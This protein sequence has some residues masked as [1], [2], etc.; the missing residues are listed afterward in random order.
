MTATPQPDQTAP[1]PRQLP[2]DTARE[3]FAWLVTGPQP[4]ALDG[5]VFP[6]LPARMIPLDELRD[7]LLRRQC[8]K[9]IRDAVWA[10]LITRARRQGASWTLACAGMALPT[11]ASTV[12]WLTARYPGDAFDV[13]AEVLTGFLNAVA[14][15][16]V[17]RPHVLARLRWAAYRA[18]LAALYEELDAPTPLPPGF[19]STPPR[20]PWGH[21]DLVLARAVREQVL[22]R[23][24]ADVIGSTRLEDISVSQW[25]TDHHTTVQSVYKMRRRAE[26]R[27]TDYLRQNET[28]QSVET[29]PVGEHVTTH[30]TGQAG[31]KAHPTESSSRNVSKLRQRPRPADAR[32][33]A[34]ALSKNRVDPGLFQCGRSTPDR[35]DDSTSEVPRCA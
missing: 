14:S 24:E 30:L 7:R 13:Q 27:L 35:P 20:P 8:P 32:K 9:T 33:V 34:S 18:G 22:T 17:D 16:D 19:R 4:L 3:C 21:P 31:A 1:D 10:Q 26:R 29:D 15:V 2:L 25:A 12:S 11:L 28:S 23:T 6:G 5:R